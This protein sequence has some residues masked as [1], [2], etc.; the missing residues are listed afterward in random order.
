MLAKVHSGAIFGVDAYSVEIEVNAGGG[1]PQTDIV[2][3]PDAAVKESKYRVFTALRNSGFETPDGRVTIN[4]APANIRKEGPDFDLPIAIG[5]LATNGDVDPV[6]LAGYG[7]VGELA[8]GGE[9]RCVRGVLPIAIALKKAGCKGFLA[10]PENVDEAAVVEGLAVYPVADLKTAVAVLRGGGP[11]PHRVDVRKIFAEPSE[12]E[13]DFAEVKGQEHAKRALEVAVAGGHNLIAIGPP[14]T[15][16]TML[17]RRIPSIM[18]PLTIEEALETTRIHSVAGLLQPRQALVVR[19]PFRA[20]HHTISDAGL[21]GGGAMPAPGEVSLAHQGVLFLDELPEFHRNAIEV[22]RQ[23]MEDGRVTISRA[24]GSITFPCRFMLVAAMNPCP[25]GFHGD[26]RRD[27][28][29]SVPQIQRYRNRISGP[30]L[31][32]MDLHIEVP[33]VRYQ[34]MA[35]VAAGEPSA[36]IRSRVLEARR[37]QQERFQA[38]RKVVCNAAMRPRDIQKFCALGAEAHALFKAA[39]SEMHLSA[40]AYDR[41]LR[42]ARTIADLVAAPDIQPEHLAEAIGYRALDRKFWS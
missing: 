18:P 15:G 29:C 2:G 13:D 24:A 39:I 35:G 34:D 8:L 5:V 36:L 16:K 20:P 33:A 38:S 12:H 30:I 4:L 41:I 22:L 21:L 42:V 14:G 17:A 27:C 10:P 1:D 6:A 25:C 26:P 31:D 23:P 3:L 28:R 37:I 32:R 40:R 9:V 19:R 7:M 11:L